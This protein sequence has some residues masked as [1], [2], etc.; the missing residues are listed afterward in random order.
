MRS[1]E[2]FF[3]LDRPLR[4]DCLDI[5]P[6]RHTW[7]TR[8]CKCM[9]E[10]NQKGRL[11]V[12]FIELMHASD[13]KSLLKKNPKP[14]MSK[15]FYITGHTELT[16]DLIWARNVNNCKKQT[17]KI[18]IKLYLSIS[19]GKAVKMYENT[20][21]SPDF[22]SSHFPKPSSKAGLESLPG[23]FR[24]PSPHCLTPLPYGCSSPPRPC[25]AAIMG[26]VSVPTQNSLT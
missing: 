17:C 12:M 13:N 14:G 24:T 3:P 18:N 20:I 21:K 2:A 1:P 25:A 26:A 8:G 15:S 5:S 16:A 23:R 6:S 11:S 19:V 10:W 9:F 4:M 7:G 22:C